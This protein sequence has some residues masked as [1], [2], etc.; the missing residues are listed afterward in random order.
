M[1]HV[2]STAVVNAVCA[3]LSCMALGCSDASHGLSESVRNGVERMSLASAADARR[4]ES[5]CDETARL[6][7]Q[8]PTREGKEVIGQLCRLYGKIAFDEQSYLARA[9]SLSRYFRLVRRMAGRLAE[10]PAFAEQAWRFQLDALGRVNRE[11]ER[12][13][14]EPP[15]G[16]YG[17][18]AALRG[19]FQ[20]QMLYLA[21][22]EEARF[23]FIREGFETGPFTRYY[24]SLSEA[25][26]KAWTRRLGETARRRVVIWDPENQMAEMPVFKA[27]SVNGKSET[28]G[29]GGVEPL[30]GGVELIMRPVGNPPNK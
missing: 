18:A 19:P 16:P 6:L 10:K 23:R 7:L 22:L 12:C 25:S 28:K 26:R 9:T 8:A 30:G 17:N 2:R 15:G 4:A 3:V 27:E 29:G 11:I 20:T 21:N 13:K 24:H 14:K 1:S 5:L